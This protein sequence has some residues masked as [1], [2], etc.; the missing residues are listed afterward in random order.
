MFTDGDFSA[1]N[2][3]SGNGGRGRGSLAKEGIMPVASK[4]TPAR[5]SSHRAGRIMTDQEK[6]EVVSALRNYIMYS[7]R[8]VCHTYVTLFCMY[9]RCGLTAD[10][11]FSNNQRS[12][13][14]RHILLPYLLHHR[15]LLPL[16]RQCRRRHHPLIPTPP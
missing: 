16:R 14:D 1:S 9:F 7:I 4:S 5:K 6:N 13:E 11:R 15:L 2:L 3:E 8:S 12:E 10:Y